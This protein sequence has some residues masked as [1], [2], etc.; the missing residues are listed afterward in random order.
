MAGR[1]NLTYEL[2]IARS[3]GFSKKALRDIQSSLDRHQFKIKN[4]RVSISNRDI[5]RIE[6]QIQKLSK[7]VTGLGKSGKQ[8]STG[9]N[10]VAKSVRQT[11]TAFTRGH[12]A[13][14]SYADS[15]GLATKRYSAFIIGAGGAVLALRK[16][17]TQ[18]TQFI[19][20]EQK[21]LVLFAQ[22]A[23]VPLG[24]KL[25]TS[26]ENQ[27]RSVAKTWGVSSTKIA[28]GVNTLLEAGLSLA[29]IDIPFL[30]KLQL[31][32]QITD[33]K[34]LSEAW[35]VLRKSFGQ[36]DTEIQRSFANMIVL[37]K[38]F[39]SS[40]QELSENLTV[41]GSLF[42]QY[43][44][45]AE[46]AWS[47]FSLAREKTLLSG[48]VI[49]NAMKTI[50]TRIFA[51]QR[52]RGVVEDLGIKLFDEE[53]VRSPVKVIQELSIALDKLSPKQKLFTMQQ[54]SGVRQINVLSALISDNAALQRIYNSTLESSD[55]V[56]TDAQIATKSLTA[57]LTK[58]KEVWQQVFSQFAG[59]GGLNAA[60][61]QLQSLSQ[62]LIGL[63]PAATTMAALFAARGGALA[64]SATFRG[65]GANVM[66]MG[67]GLRRQRGLGLRGMAT[68]GI[69]RNMPS[70]RAMVGGATTLGAVGAFAGASQTENPQLKAGLAAL[71][72][73]LV[74]ASLGFGPL[75]IALGAATVGLITL[76]KATERAKLA[77]D[78]RAVVTGQTRV[79]DI[80]TMRGK[81]APATISAQL[82]NLKNIRDTMQERQFGDVGTFQAGMQAFVSGTNK[83]K[84]VIRQRRALQFQG[85]AQKSKPQ[86]QDLAKFISTQTS[87]LEEFRRF[88]LGGNK[89]IGQQLIETIGS[90]DGAAAAKDFVKALKG[91]FA[92]VNDELRNAQIE[93]QLTAS[94][95]KA[96]TGISTASTQLTHGIERLAR[97]VTAE[98]A[99][100]YAE[101][102]SIKLTEEQHTKLQTSLQKFVA[103]VEADSAKLSA[104]RKQELQMRQNIIGQRMKIQ[105][106][107]FALGQHLSGTTTPP[108]IAQINS[109]Q[110]QGIATQTG[111]PQGKISVQGLA[112]THAALTK[113]KEA[114]ENHIKTLSVGTSEHSQAILKYQML[115]SA[116]TNVSAGLT[117]L[118]N[119]T[120][121]LSE[122]QRQLGLLKADKS[123]RLGFA[124]TFAL[125][126][127]A[128]QAKLRSGVKL[129]KQY[130][131]KDIS[132]L[133]VQARTAIIST[134]DRLANVQLGKG[135]KTGADLKRTTLEASYKNLTAQ[136]Q[137]IKEKEA[138]LKQ[139][140]TGLLTRKLEV[141]IAQGKI[142]QDSVN[143]FHQSVSVFADSLGVKAQSLPGAP[144]QL[145][146]Q[147]VA[148]GISINTAN[149]QS[150]LEPLKHI[151]EK[152][153]H[154]GEHNVNV[155]VNGAQVLQEL[156]AGPLSE[157]IRSEIQRSLSI[158]INPLT[159]ETES[160][161]G[162]MSQS[163]IRSGMP[164]KMYN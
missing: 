31:N 11:G 102:N 23:N 15:I 86:I 138:T 145:P 140:I 154:T 149:L 147:Q 10:Q 63:I 67:G 12:R 49:S 38:Q 157:L 129:A 69:L 20:F 6:K 36:G 144:Q 19:D 93:E 109:L 153:T 152:I 114:T 61:K 14:T 82:Q 24:G 26:F 115:N 131:G 127:V 28:E 59:G 141:E 88:S 87:S 5:L 113:L 58:L 70:R 112:D 126:N 66:A 119:V 9:L 92:K 68:M 161:I 91:T 123:G 111:L 105:Q 132:G 90:I 39:S 42:A 139:E 117:E 13:A 78:T 133:D 155:T 95:E 62:V 8:A 135:G 46:E 121:Q 44:A 124:Q 1:Y 164:K 159:G 32:R 51:Q 64:A 54:I 53:G 76:S 55:V 73:G 100:R 107:G 25:A 101:L 151:P 116:I 103:S 110:R 137:H 41:V 122:A 148:Q 158:S 50:F 4:L 96:Q 27:I 106:T 79:Q 163:L 71:G 18:L 52:S 108:S 3:S 94:F 81:F 21:A 22:I 17:Q 120:R 16:L 45:S 7:K 75:G 125:S 33:I 85:V 143:T 128:D 104:L 2:G 47:L 146:P 35:L 80:A 65:A 56:T 84:G 162:L 30:A 134:F 156:L 57:E 43:N 160:N 99:A 150:V 34:G 97:V 136:P 40:A 29:E 89:N 60:V 142:M 72:T 98:E 130:A 77:E 74:A 83:A 118:G 37:S 48:N